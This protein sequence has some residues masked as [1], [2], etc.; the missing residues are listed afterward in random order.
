MLYNARRIVFEQPR[1]LPTF[2]LATLYREKEENL[3]NNK[4]QFFI[5][6]SEETPYVREFV[7]Q[8]Q[9]LNLTVCG[10]GTNKT[11]LDITQVR[12][13][14]QITVGSSPNFDVN[15][16]K[17]D[18]YFC[19]KGYAPVYDIVKDWNKIEKA[20]KQFADQKKRMYTLDGTDIKFHAR[21][22][23]IDGK[24]VPY[25]K[26]QVIA[27]VPAVAVQDILNEYEITVKVVRNW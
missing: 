20:L 23:V 17:R 16:V 18:Q 8:A 10:D 9:D 12:K 7:R 2:T 11:R 6:V 14:D 1:Q 26:S 4:G 22:M 13:G 5:N 24:V 25:E 3:L 15:W 19:Q 27:L 21:F